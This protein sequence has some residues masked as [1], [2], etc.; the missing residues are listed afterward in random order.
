MIHTAGKASFLDAELAKPRCKPEGGKAENVNE[1]RHYY[2]LRD[3]GTQKQTRTEK[4]ARASGRKPGDR[5][6][7]STI[8]MSQEPSATENKITTAKQKKDAG[9]QA[10]ISGQLKD[11]T[12]IVLSQF[13]Q[14]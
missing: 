14:L 3:A 2:F 4:S 12:A 11:G 13:L 5:I 8:I 6:R 9:D 1:Q 7:P 10:F